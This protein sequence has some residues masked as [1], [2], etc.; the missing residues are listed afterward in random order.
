MIKERIIYSNYDLSDRYEEAKQYLIEECDIENPTDEEIW[1]K[2]YFEDE[3]CFEDTLEELKHFFKNKNYLFTCVI[4][5]WRGV[6]KGGK[7]GSNFEK[8]FYN[9]V[10]DCNYIK[11]WDENGHLYIKATHHDGTNFAEIKILNDKGYQVFDNWD[12]DYSNK[13]TEQEM[14]EM[15]YNNN[16][17]SSLPHFSHKVYGCPKKESVKATRENIKEK[18]SNK[19]CSYYSGYFS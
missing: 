9:F 3:I 1:E 15:L 2:I 19:A 7:I 5:T 10:T 13:K 14:H 12:Y 8:D 4:G 6:C 18:L 11:I 17:Y 16:F